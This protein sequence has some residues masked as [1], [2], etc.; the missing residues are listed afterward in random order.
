L[1]T[2]QGSTKGQAGQGELSNG[3]TDPPLIGTLLNGF[4]SPRALKTGHKKQCQ[5]NIR[6]LAGAISGVVERR[7]LLGHHLS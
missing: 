1:P 4:L 7:R 6:Q 3:I 2:G 5:Q